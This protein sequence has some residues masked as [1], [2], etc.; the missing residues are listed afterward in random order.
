MNHINARDPKQILIVD[1]HAV[2]RRSQSR[3]QRFRSQRAN[4]H[5]LQNTRHA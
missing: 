4:A 1:D 3:R 2:V 5:G